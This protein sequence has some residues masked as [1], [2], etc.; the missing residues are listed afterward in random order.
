M[1]RAFF[2]QDASPTITIFLRNSVLDVAIDR[3]TDETANKS[4]LPWPSVFL[5]LCSFLTMDVTLVLEVVA[6]SDSN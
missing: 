1:R 5:L 4:P 6:K 2:S 3:G